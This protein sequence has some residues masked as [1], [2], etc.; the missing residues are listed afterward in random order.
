VMVLLPT[1]KGKAGDA[2]PEATVFPLMVRVAK[3]LVADAVTLID[4]VALD[5]VDV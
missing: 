2:A 5:T 4:V 1:F 3:A